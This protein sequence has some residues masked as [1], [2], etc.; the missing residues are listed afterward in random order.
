MTV[1]IRLPDQRIYLKKRSGQVIL[2]TFGQKFQK[3]LKKLSFLIL[4]FT[5]AFSLSAQSLDEILNSYIENTGGLEKWNSLK[6][7]RMTGKMSMSGFEFSGVISA[8]TPNK[9][10]VDVDVQ[11]QKLVQ[12]YDG[13][14]AWWINPFQTG[15]DAQ[16][17]PEEMAEEM[18]KEEFENPFINYKDK[19]H[20]AELL[21]EETIEGTVT[22]KVKLTKKNGDIEV[23]FFDKEYFVPV[24][25]QS[26][27][28]TG[29][30]KGQMSETY[31][32]DYQE[33]EGF[34][35]PFFLEVKI[36]GESAQKITIEKAEVNVELEDSLFTYPKK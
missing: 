32:S 13:E 27:I 20:T 30:T 36:G 19:G 29:P 10:R 21:G 8:K 1:R 35:M 12:A 23:Y 6:T 31:F 16:P 4:A 7:T 3:M 22:F 24:M 28:T 26:P 15:P 5:A 34:M 33:V 14:T 2:A 18:K 25:M 17:M 11:G 9:Q